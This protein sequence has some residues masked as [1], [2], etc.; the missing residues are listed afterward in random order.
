MRV[1]AYK[2]LPRLNFWI[3]NHIHLWLG[4]NERRTTIEQEEAFSEWTIT[5]LNART[6]YQY[7]GA[8]MIALEAS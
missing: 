6:I 8:I 2:V 5:L 7:P 3:T 4:I 1:T